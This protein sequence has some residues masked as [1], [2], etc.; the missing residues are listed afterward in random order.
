MKVLTTI[1]HR[2]IQRIQLVEFLTHE[3][4]EVFGVVIALQLANESRSQ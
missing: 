2:V 1:Y 4:I 3:G